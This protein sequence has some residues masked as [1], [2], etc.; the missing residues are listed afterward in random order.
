MHGRLHDIVLSVEEEDS[1][2]VNQD[3]VED[4]SREQDSPLAR[5]NQ[6]LKEL[7]NKHPHL[8]KVFDGAY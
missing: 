6:E 7:K 1:Q 2:P 8:L 4:D 3:S 5:V